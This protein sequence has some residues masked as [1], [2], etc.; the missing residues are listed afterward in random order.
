MGRQGS[1]HSVLRYIPCVSRIRNYHMKSCKL[2][3]HLV[4][5]SLEVRFQNPL[6]LLQLTA[7]QLGIA[8]HQYR[9]RFGVG[10]RSPTP[11]KN[12]FR[13]F[14]LLANSTTHHPPHNRA[15][16][17]RNQALLYICNRIIGLW[18][19]HRPTMPG[20]WVTTHW[21]ESLGEF[22]GSV[23]GQIDV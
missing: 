18:K 16:C 17:T 3:K 6:P 21:P 12:L 5:A 19:T 2:Q 9:H 13:F 11:R 20:T 15:V 1:N 10:H 23:S 7:T 22:T 14:K 4:R 8:H